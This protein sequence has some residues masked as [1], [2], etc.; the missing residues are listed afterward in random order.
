MEQD[1]GLGRLAIVLLPVVTLG[2]IVPLRNF[3]VEK[4][5]QF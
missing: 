4:G 3:T 5:T 1:I 2:L